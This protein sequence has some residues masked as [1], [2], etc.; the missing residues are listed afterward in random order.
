MTAQVNACIYDESITET[1]YL[2]NIFKIMI[3]KSCY[4]YLDVLQVITVR[5]HFRQYKHILIYQAGRISR[6][7]V[8]LHIL[9]TKCAFHKQHCIK[10]R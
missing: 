8:M 10:A 9:A 7:T 1:S 2:N 6:K 5:L 4:R 3:T